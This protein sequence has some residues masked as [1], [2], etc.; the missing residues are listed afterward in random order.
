MGRQDRGS[1]AGHGL[2]VGKTS[3]VSGCSDA[4]IV[5]KVGCGGSAT[6]PEGGSGHAAS[7]PGSGL[8]GHTQA[9][10]RDRQR[11][12][13]RPQ[14]RRILAARDGL[15]PQSRLDPGNAPIDARKRQEYVVHLEGSWR[16]NALVGQ[17]LGGDRVPR[18]WRNDGRFHDGR[19]TPW[20][21]PS[22]NSTADAESPATTFFYLVHATD[23]IGGSAE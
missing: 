14:R 3:S 9:V 6:C 19:P 4:A 17:R 8:S 18:L 12:G 10:Q 20:G 22:T 1:S 13:H 15:V 11:S 23:G 5:D 21:T 7:S 2:R 16:C